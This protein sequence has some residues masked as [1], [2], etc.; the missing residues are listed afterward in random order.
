MS[1]EKLYGVYRG[2]VAGNVDPEMAGR[3]SVALPADAGGGTLWAP[4]ARPVASIADEVPEVGAEV[5]VAFEAGDPDRPFVIGMVR[6]DP[7]TPAVRNLRMRSGYEV[8]IDEPGQQLRLL[9]S[10]G[11]ECVLADDGTLTITAP[12]LNIHTGTARFD[13]IIIC[14]TMIATTGVISP[15]YTPGVGNLM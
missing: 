10:N 2:L 4:V 7:Q 6:H 11:T 5:L 1:N 14:T 8:V 15:S 13:G 9:H 3:V 12:V